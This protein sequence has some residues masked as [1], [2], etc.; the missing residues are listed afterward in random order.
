MRSICR[1]MTHLENEAL[2][3]VLWES[4]LGKEMIVVGDFNLPNIHWKLPGHL[5]FDHVPT[6]GCPVL[7]WFCFNWTDSMGE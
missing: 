1:G 2:A 6:I 4:I 3:R 7:R 5:P